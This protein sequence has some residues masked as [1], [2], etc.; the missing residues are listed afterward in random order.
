LTRA[1]DSV[2]NTQPDDVPLNR[3]GY[4]YNAPVPHPVTVG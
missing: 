4:L 1:T 3:E 2:G